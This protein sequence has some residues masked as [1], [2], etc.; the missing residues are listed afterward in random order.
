M[1]V[2]ALLVL[3]LLG[4]R[5]A[6]AT[7]YAP[8]AKRD[9]R[10]PDGA[11][12]LHVDPAAGRLTVATTADPA[13][14]VWSVA[15]RIQFEEYFVAPGGQHIGVVAWRFIQ[16][17]KL[18]DPGVEI[19][20]ASGPVARYSI[21]SLVSQPSVIHGVG[22]IGP[23]WRDWLAGTSQD[24]ARLV[25]ETTGLHRYVFDLTAGRQTASELRLDGV[26]VLAVSFTFLLVAAALVVW[27]RRARRH[28]E[29]PAE[30]L[31]YG[32]A[33]APPIAAL[34][35]LWLHAGGALF[36]PAEYLAMPRIA[37]AVFAI[38]LTPVALLAIARL[39]AG[40]RVVRL[41]LAITTPIVIGVVAFA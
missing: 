22:P 13:T 33:V 24:G 39:P 40:Q 41:L 9:V 2:R 12:V 34:V 5:I 35:W 31:R 3:L 14:P 23:F 32:L 29:W 21:R 8:P 1:A 16:V 36:V 19:L 17:D 37:L 4:V 20:G 28:A 10:S 7:S 15:R 26:A 6:A 38:G 30:K 27:T 11:F 18:D 25:V